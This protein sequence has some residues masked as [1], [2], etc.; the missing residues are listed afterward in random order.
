[1]TATEI[2]VLY[3]LCTLMP[4]TISSYIGGRVHQRRREDDQRRA[5]F[6]EGFLRASTLLAVP[7][8]RET[9]HADLFR[10]HW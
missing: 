3:F 4:A 9:R 10:S 1:M 2:V 5:A 8:G 7:G 6:R